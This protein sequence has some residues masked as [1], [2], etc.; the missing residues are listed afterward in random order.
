MGPQSLIDYVK[1]QNGRQFMLGEHDCFTFTNGAWHVMHG[2][3]YADQF[4]GKYAGLKKR[5]FSKAM[6]DAFG[7]DDLVTALDTVLCRFD[8]IPPRG[9]LVINKSARP[10]FTGYAMGIAMGVNAVFLSEQSVVY[11]PISEIDGA[12]VKCRS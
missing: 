1:A 9:A 2:H 12:W 6:K 8:G 3:G 11:A 10:Y 4:I 5:A 7:S